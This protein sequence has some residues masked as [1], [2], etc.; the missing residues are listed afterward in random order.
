[1]RSSGP[2]PSP[3]SSRPP[4]S[5][6]RGPDDPGITITNGGFT[7]DNFA[8][9]LDNVPIGAFTLNYIDLS[10]ASA[11]DVWSGAGQVTFPTGLVDLGEHDVRERRRWTI[12][13]AYNAGTSTG[14]AIPD[15]GMFVTEISG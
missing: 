9:S 7:V 4:C 5:S 13:L 8:F 15:T 14:I 10:Y 2:S 1:M 12:S 11:G 6:G 3:T